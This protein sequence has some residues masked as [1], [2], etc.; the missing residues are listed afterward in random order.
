DR[1]LIQVLLSGG[2]QPIRVV[3]R[4]QALR[5]LADGFRSPQV[6]ST[7]GLSAKTVRNIGWRYVQAGLHR[8]LYEAPRPGATPLLT[9][10][11]KQHIIAMVCA[12]PPTG[13]ARWTIRLI[14]EECKRRKLVSTVGR[15]P[16]AYC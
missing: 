4:A 3:K 10:S 16:F 5:L 14:A 15:E 11:Q 8:A 9:D 2:V 12:D 1:R 13:R 7:V 6:G